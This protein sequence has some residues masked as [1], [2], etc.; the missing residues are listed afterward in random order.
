MVMRDTNPNN[1]VS[2]IINTIE[3]TDI[4]PL[5]FM[6]KHFLFIL[7]SHSFCKAEEHHFILILL[8]K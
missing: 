4:V 1:A 2:E 7:S 8:L 3:V 6:L 5:C